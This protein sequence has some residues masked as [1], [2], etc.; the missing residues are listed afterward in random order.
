MNYSTCG[1]HA[2][3]F[4]ICL[5]KGH[6]KYGLLDLRRGARNPDSET[7]SATRP[8]EAGC[9]NDLGNSELMSIAKAVG[10]SGIRKAPVFWSGR[11]LIHL[12]ISG[13][14]AVQLS[15]QPVLIENIMVIQQEN[16]PTEQNWIMTSSCSNRVVTTTFPL[17]QEESV[18]NC[19]VLIGTCEACPIWLS[20]SREVSKNQCF[21]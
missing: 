8:C 12:T 6:V 14:T 7:C 3:S 1:F 21:I 13:Q 5:W 10:E 17:S 16:W 9:S 2:A 20:E 19:L 15:G 4:I 11:R 18:S